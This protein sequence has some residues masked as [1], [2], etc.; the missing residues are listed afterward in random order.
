MSARP[1][2]RGA[3][4]ITAGL[5]LA[6]PLG[7]LTTPS[8][9]APTPAIK[10]TATVDTLFP[11]V[12]N[13]GYDVRHYDIALTY[14]ATNG[15]IVAKTVITAKAAKRL[16]S[17]TL[18]LEGLTVDRVRV[19]GKAATF[20]R[21]KNKLVV[22]P[23][24]PVK[25][26]FTTTVDYHGVPTTHIDPDGAPDGWIPTTDGATTLNEPVGAMT[27]FPNN[28]TPRDKATFD[29]AI[30]VPS[31]LEVASNGV[32]RSQQE[33]GMQTTWSWREK[34][35]MATYLAMISIGDYDVY[36]ST[37]KLR[38]GKTLP[39]WSFI[40]PSLGS[41]SDQRKL[42]PEVIRFQ[43]ARYGPYPFDS[44][45]IVV[46]PIEVGYALETQ[47]RPFF[48]QTPD[49]STIVHEFAH[50]WYGNSVTPK[51]WGDIWL[52]EGF[53]TYAESVWDQAH[54][55]PSTAATFQQIYDANDAASSL[56][57]P[58]PADLRDPE[59]LFADPVYVRGSLTLEALRMRVGTKDL[60]T[61]LKR[62]AQE[63]K[64]KT[65]S[66]AQF[67]ALSERVSG[68]NLD[69]FFRTWLY[70]ASKPKGY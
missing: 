55:G 25:G 47:E 19:D 57:T 60:N 18:D 69:P 10:A 64:G 31:A 42:I 28:N 33:R 66:T 68:K 40:D 58:A 36:Y 4:L 5:L 39:I 37:M 35:P 54:G 3:R 6:L 46:K 44:A 14:R 12:G 8:Q 15:A 61:I 50:Q 26:T 2:R 27:W 9:A 43:E 23:A 63:K 16:T 32:L 1:L 7:L 24:S 22:T 51:D 62:W 52:N 20:T 38:S 45:G 34:Q 49:T 48:D 56:W 30:T 53:A 65:V 41:L 21:S 17:F 67:I 70:R 13:A 11:E 59:F 29:F